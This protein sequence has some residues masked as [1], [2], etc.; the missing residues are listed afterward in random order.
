MIYKINLL[1]FSLLPLSL[2][3]SNFIA[4]FTIS[5]MS[6]TF[7]FLIIKNKNFEYLNNYF[8]FIFFTWWLYLILTSI[9]SNDIQFSFESSLFYIRFIL[10]ALSISFFIEKDK[11]FFK[12]FLFVI[13]FTFLL[14]AI[15]SFIQLVFGFNILLYEISDT[16]IFGS[17]VSSFFKDEYILGSFLVRLLPFILIFYIFFMNEKIKYAKLSIIF[18]LSI[19]DLTIFISGERTAILYLLL[20]SVSFFIFSKKIRDIIIF[21]N[22][23]TIFLI[24][25]TLFLYENI[26][27]RVFDYTIYQ[28]FENNQNIIKPNHES[29]DK[30]NKITLDNNKI[31][32]NLQKNNLISIDRSDLNNFLLIEDIDI[33]FFSVQHEV[34]Y[35]TALKIFQDNY[36]FGIGP[37]MFR[38][39]CKDTKYSTFSDLDKT[40]DG[41]QSHPHNSYIQL[42][43]ETGIIG[44][45]F[46]FIFFVYVCYKLF[47]NSILEKKLNFNSDKSNLALFCIFMTLWPI[48]PTGNF[49]HNWLNIIYYLPIGFLIYFRKSNNETTY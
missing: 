38:K 32:N 1:F 31:N 25:C 16:G 12:F 14:L 48:V 9:L 42:L 33:S 35:K 46:V 36:I 17:R 22:I 10:F 8:F 44:F 39:I 5:L 27:K 26:R 21:K 49:F 2:V 19:I 43:S 34:V 4:D 47:I 29:N 15:D 45:L 3:F 24:V 7:L 28:L 40:I 18:C 11:N 20:F 30:Q 13:F 41:C 23:F 6:L 37:K